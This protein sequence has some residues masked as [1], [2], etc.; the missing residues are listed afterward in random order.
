MALNILIISAVF[1]D[2]TVY[3]HA[4]FSALPPYLSAMLFAATLLIKACQRHFR[5]FIFFR[6]DAFDAAAI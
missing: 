6:F 3:A 2:T 4:Y 1:A 5:Y